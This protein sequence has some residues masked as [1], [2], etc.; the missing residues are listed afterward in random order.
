MLNSSR[1]NAYQLMWVLVMYDL[2]TVTKKE[3]KLA[4][5]F[6]KQILSDGFTMFQFS[7]YVRHCPSRENAEVHI[8]RVKKI[9]PEEGLVGIFHITD[10]QFGDIQ[11][12]RGKKSTTP[13]EVSYQLEL[14]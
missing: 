6:R 1:Y 11:I 13:P 8:M 12:F 2:P 14:F 4:A 7:M 5:K 9:V 3:K 10:K